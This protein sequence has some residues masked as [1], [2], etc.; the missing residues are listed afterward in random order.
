MLIAL[1]TLLGPTGAAQAVSKQNAAQAAKV[2]IPLSHLYVHFYL[3]E[4]HVERVALAHPHAAAKGGS[5]K[6][7]LR[8][9]AGLSQA[10][11]QH[12]TAS[13]QRMESALTAF[14]AQSQALIQSDRAT[15]KVS[16]MACL[17]APPN[18][19]KLSQL[20][21]QR[22][23]AVADE[24]SS[25]ESALGA[26]ATRKFRAFLQGD[27]ANHIKVFTN[28]PATAPPSQGA[29]QGVQP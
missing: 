8:K 14:N 27:F 1:L 29:N 12:V 26:E 3:Y 19:Q 24:N 22:E 7:H 16:T 20:H 11:W 21:K 5:A 9:R 23:Q 2:Q 25:L 28:M 15:C 13:S 10:E 18:L 6:D 17:P 4:A